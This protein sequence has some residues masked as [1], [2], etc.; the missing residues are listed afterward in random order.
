MR[1]ELS[2]RLS[3]KIV[4]DGL[5]T[6]ISID[7]L[8]CDASSFRDLLYCRTLLVTLDVLAEKEQKTVKHLCFGELD[9]LPHGEEGFMFLFTQIT[10]L[11]SPCGV[12]FRGQLLLLLTISKNNWCFGTVLASQ[13][14]PGLGKREIPALRSA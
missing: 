12:I 4:E 5:N 14:A 10:G 7:F 11:K 9:F 1:S 8:H 2:F 13:L 6:Q 3:V